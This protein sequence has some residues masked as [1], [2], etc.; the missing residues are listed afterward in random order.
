LD[1]VVYDKTGASIVIEPLD[2][3]L[4]VSDNPLMEWSGRAPTV[5][6]RQTGLGQQRAGAS[7]V[8]QAQWCNHQRD[9]HRYR[10]E[11]VPPHWSGPARRD[12]AAAEVVARAG[13]GAA[14]QR[15][16]VLDR[17]GSLR[18]GP[19]LEPQAAGAWARCP[20]DAGEVRAPVLEGAE[21]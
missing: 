2:G 10:Q 15:A 9:W 21:E 5:P 14:R 20:A 17:D 18:R 13:G 16:T 8:Q 4:K 3:K 1:F 12:R 7:H 19:S 6:A 11:L